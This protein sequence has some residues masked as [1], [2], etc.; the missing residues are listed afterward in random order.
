MADKG[1]IP[2]EEIGQKDRDRLL[3]RLDHEFTC[4]VQR[5]FG[6]RERIKVEDCIDD[7]VGDSCA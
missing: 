1:Y 3:H 2:L 4:R 7:A 5:R 6:Q